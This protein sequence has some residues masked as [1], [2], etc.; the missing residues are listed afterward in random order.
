MKYN[1]VIVGDRMKKARLL[2][3]VLLTLL[4]GLLF[5]NRD[6]LVSFA[7]ENDVNMLN[8][9]N[10]IKNNTS[11]VFEDYIQIDG[12]RSR[13]LIVEYRDN[14]YS[15]ISDDEVCTSQGVTNMHIEINN[16]ASEFWLIDDLYIDSTKG[17]LI[18]VP[19][20]YMAPDFYLECSP[21]KITLDTYATCKVTAE[22]YFV[23]SNIEFNLEL[24]DFIIY[25]EV[26]LNDVSNLVKN[27]NH[28]SLT[29]KKVL[30]YGLSHHDEFTPF[31]NPVEIE[32]MEFKIKTEKDQEIKIEKNIH[33][34]DLKYTDIVGESS[35]ELLTSTVGQ[36]MEK[37]YVEG[38]N[39]SHEENPETMD[40]ILKI[41]G[42]FVIS[43]A[44]FLT[45]KMKK[46]EIS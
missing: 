36:D 37:E 44:L 2:S 15:Y 6:K 42:I 30:P 8:E 4:L 11:F 21:S 23:L 12:D 40:V 43:F 46:K 34:A 38:D 3:I 19:F 45:F 10:V 18:L 31:D 9:M 14:N 27:D 32:L 25:D 7:K 26:K 16:D 1:N 35:Y 29:P 13:C 41:V 39:V 24:D 20:E 5:V 33:L 17:V 28:Y 22:T